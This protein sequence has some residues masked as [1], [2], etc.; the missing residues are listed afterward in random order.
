[1]LKDAKVYNRIRELREAGLWDSTKLP[2]CEDPPRRKTH[3]D[4]VLE[5][6]LWMATDFKNERK[7]KRHWARKVCDFNGKIY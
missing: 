3:W 2:K 6:V 4:Y 5:E 7:T 1:M